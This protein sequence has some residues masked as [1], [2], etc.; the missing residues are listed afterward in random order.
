MF[1]GRLPYFPGIREASFNT[2]IIQPF[3]FP[4]RGY[5]IVNTPVMERFFSSGEDSF[6]PILNSHLQNKSDR[7]YDIQDIQMYLNY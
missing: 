4:G 6:I 2:S 1:K 5:V 3:S 7:V